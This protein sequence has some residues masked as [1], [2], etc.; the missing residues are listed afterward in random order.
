MFLVE[1]SRHVLTCRLIDIDLCHGGTSCLTVVLMG[2]MQR[3]H[4]NES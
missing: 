1:A 3:V 4:C 2:P